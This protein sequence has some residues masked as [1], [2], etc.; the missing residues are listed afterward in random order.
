MTTVCPVNRMLEFG[1]RGMTASDVVLLSL[2]MLICKG[3]SAISL[4]GEY[5][6]STH[7][8]SCVERAVVDGNVVR[9]RKNVCS[10]H[11]EWFKVGV[12]V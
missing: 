3:S 4:L 1:I 2:W 5:N 7:G 9:I 8:V 10:A 11:S 12:R 6:C